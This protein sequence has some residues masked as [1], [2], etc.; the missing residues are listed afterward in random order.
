MSRHELR[1]LGDEE[2][3][4]LTDR[5]PG[6]EPARQAGARELQTGQETQGT[7][8][9]GAATTQEQRPLEEQQQAEEQRQRQLLAGKSAWRALMAPDGQ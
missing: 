4:R 2:R 8:E 3:I 7:Q 9:T 5:T 6:A 1:R